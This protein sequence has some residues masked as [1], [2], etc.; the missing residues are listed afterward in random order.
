MNYIVSL[1]MLIGIPLLVPAQFIDLED[2]IIGYYPF[3]GSAADMTGNGNDAFVNEAELITDRFGN[4]NGAY[5]FDG[6]QQGLRI[7]FAEMMDFTDSR[8]Y[9]ISL[10]IRPRDINTGCIIM[11]NYDYG[12]KWGG[13]KQACTIYSGITSSFMETNFS[14]WRSENWYNLVV[15]QAVEKISFYVNGKLDFEENRPHETA[16]QTEDIYI[17]RHPYFWGAF[18]GDIDDICI[19]NRPLDPL[20]AEALYQI[21]TMP[22]E[23]KPKYNYAEIDPQAIAGTWQGI[24]TQPGNANFDNYAYWLDLEVIGNSVKGFARVEIAN[25]DAY[26]IMTVQGNIS[27]S[28]LNLS[29]Q[30]ITREVNPSALDWCMKFT[31]L[32]FD[33]SEQALR[34]RWL[35]DNCKEDGEIVLFRSENPF[36]FYENQQGAYASLDEITTIL[37]SNV[38]KVPEQRESVVNRR[39]DIDP[40][41]FVFGSSQLTTSSEDYLN[42]TL[43]PFLKKAQQIKLKIS[44]HTDDVGDDAINLRLSIERAQSV[45]KYIQGKSIAEERLQY[46]GF[47]E[48]KP[49]ADNKSSEGRS[50][51]RRVE[52]KIIEE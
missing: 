3:N 21:E 4:P 12:V 6:R 14:Y 17:G 22:V 11:K 25:T 47:G 7:P 41:S 32:R 37:A 36:N 44:G 49:I 9:S 18:E 40:I 15:V 50:K 20:E 30:Q 33:P 13:M 34:G 31:K 23:L 26:G 43:V 46:E 28:A 5:R 45:A 52:I 38:T 39:I 10:W 51:N 42:N 29:E 19:F 16:S 48:S 35:A 1:L 27:S 8:E 24:F 2:G